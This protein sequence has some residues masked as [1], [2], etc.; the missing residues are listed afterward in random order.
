MG[1][2]Y[3]AEAN[4]SQSV[5]LIQ[6]IQRGFVQAPCMRLQTHVLLIKIYVTATPQVP[7]Y[8]ITGENG[9]DRF[10]GSDGRR[11]VSGLDSRESCSTTFGERLFEIWSGLG[12]ANGSRWRYQDTRL[13]RFLIAMILSVTPILSLHVAFSKRECP[14]VRRIKKQTSLKVFQDK[15]LDKR[16]R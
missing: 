16:Q 5:P 7:G 14:L 15:L 8:V 6:L 2:L 10:P 13:D 3:N 12:S 1:R 11:P 9:F 4:S